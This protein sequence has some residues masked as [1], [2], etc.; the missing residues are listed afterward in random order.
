[1]DNISCLILGMTGNDMHY[2]LNKNDAVY[3]NGYVSKGP[4]LSSTISASIHGN[5]FILAKNIQ[6]TLSSA[7]HEF[8]QNVN[9]F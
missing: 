9:Y 6:K 8:V 5:I 4:Y 3:T 1:M 2:Q 7:L